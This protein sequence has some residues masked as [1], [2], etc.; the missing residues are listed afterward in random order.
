MP[1]TTGNTVTYS[2]DGQIDTSVVPT[3]GCYDI[4]AIG[5]VGGATVGGD[6]AAGKGG[7]GMVEPSC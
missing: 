3:K 7:A 6:G 5:A 1:S 2:Y 4:T